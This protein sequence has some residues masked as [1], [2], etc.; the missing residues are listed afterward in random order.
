MS[1][2]NSGEQ[3]HHDQK[4]KISRDLREEL[5]D[6][7]LAILAEDGLEHL[8]LRKVA[9]RVGVSHAAPAH[10]FTGLPELLG[11]V[12]KVGFENLAKAMRERLDVA[13]DDPHSHLIAAGEG[14]V[15]FARQNAGLISLMFNA[16]REKV[17]KSAF[18]G[19]G[20][21][22]YSLLKQVSAPF[23]PVGAEP[24]STETLIWSVVHGF[25]FLH[26][27]GRFDNSGRSTAEP[28]IADILPRLK[29][30]QG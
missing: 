13:N 27:G 22:T 8:S 11:C 12:C 1:S 23:E 28:Q 2:K 16:G 24:D 15:N 3:N 6:A 20:Q 10:H 17:E 5:I 19:S 21:E 18:G 25:A 26:I 9:A 4:A 7:A 29:L 14:Y 30:R